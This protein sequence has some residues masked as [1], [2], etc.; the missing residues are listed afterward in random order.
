MDADR[1]TSPPAAGITAAAGAAHTSSPRASRPALAPTPSAHPDDPPQ[2]PHDVDPD[3]YPDVVDPVRCAT[4]YPELLPAIT[5]A[6]LRIG[7]SEPAKA[8]AAP[9]PT[10]DAVLATILA[11]NHNLLRAATRLSLPLRELLQILRQPDC[12]EQLKDLREATDEL[13]ALRAAQARITS[14]D[15]LEKAALAA[16]KEGDPIELRRAA[17]ALSRA[18]TLRATAGAPPVPAG[19][20][21]NHG[22]EV[23]A[24]ALRPRHKPRRGETPIEIVNK[25]VTALREEGHPHPGSAAATFHAYAA[26]GA[27]L[28][29]NPISDDL[30]EFAEAFEESRLHDS[31]HA[32]KAIINPP[33]PSGQLPPA[34]DEHGRPLFTLLLFPSPTSSTRDPDRR[35]T[36]VTITFTPSTMLNTTAVA[37]PGEQD[38]PLDPDQTAQPYWLINTITA[39][40]HQR[41]GTWGS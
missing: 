4:L 29:H 30:E 25:L 15:L 22:D 9:P 1:T 40:R 21:E 2:D 28:D 17:T 5:A 18:T 20:G 8:A 13:L 12:R 41:P 27:T 10:A 16:E 3:P 39:S 38:S 33:D 32:S 35:P 7:A 23:P 6:Q 11:E 19:S 34:A 14:I 37:D 24:R 36:R 26:P 31:L